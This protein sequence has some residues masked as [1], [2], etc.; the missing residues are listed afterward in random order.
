V[1]AQARAVEGKT[2][3]TR[4]SLSAGI[5]L[6]APGA[7]DQRR[8]AI[9]EAPIDALVLVAAGLNTIATCGTSFQP[10]LIEE[11]VGRDLLIG[12]DADR[13]GDEFTDKL[14]AELLGRSTLRRLRP[15][16]VKDWA[17]LADLEGLDSVRAQITAVLQATWRVEE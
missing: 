14:A 16:G 9:T 10:W 4:G 5:F 2:K 11:L 1:A 12:S 6:A 3:N 8:I 15:D 7:L 13:G 17:E